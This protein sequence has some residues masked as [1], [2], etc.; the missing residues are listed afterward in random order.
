MWKNILSLA[1]LVLS[2]GISIHL[3]PGANAEPKTSLGNNP[4]ASYGGY[5]SGNTFTVFTNPSDQAFVVKTILT[6]SGCD[7]Y[8]GGNMILSQGSYFTPTLYW[9]NAGSHDNPSSGTPFTSGT[10]NLHIPAGESLSIHN[11]DNIRYYV[12]G[13]SVHP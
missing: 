13:Y 4:V 6:S 10:A 7:I 2:I 9:F 8:V 11:C 12:D 5:I 1:A 3:I